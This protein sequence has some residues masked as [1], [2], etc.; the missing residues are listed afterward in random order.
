MIEQYKQHEEGQKRMEA[1]QFS[2][3]IVPKSG[4]IMIKFLYIFMFRCFPG[5]PPSPTN[6]STAEAAQKPKI[7]GL[8]LIQVVV[9]IA[10][11]VCPKVTHPANGT[12][13]IRAWRMTQHASVSAPRY[14]PPALSP[15][16]KG[17]S[18]LGCL[19]LHNDIYGGTSQ[20]VTPEQ[21]K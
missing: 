8:K 12:Q 11:E 4:A 21:I 2:I 13:T 15:N 1:W 20:L 9:A 17:V 14:L 3:Y 6:S 7:V 18:C 5:F 16:W 10:L 19:A